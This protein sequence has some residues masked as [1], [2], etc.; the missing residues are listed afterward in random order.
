MFDMVSFVSNIICF[1]TSTSISSFVMSSSNLQ[2][3][4]L[5]VSSF[6]QVCSSSGLYLNIESNHI[7]QFILF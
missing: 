6:K 2:A 3:L 5:S 1:R 4:L 7:K